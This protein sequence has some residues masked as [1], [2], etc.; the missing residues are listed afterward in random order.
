M[1]I[2]H[3][4][5][6]NQ[7]THIMQAINAT[8]FKKMREWYPSTD[9]KMSFF[10]CS[11]LLSQI[12]LQVAITKI[13]RDDLELDHAL[14]GE[15]LALLIKLSMQAVED[16]GGLRS[17]RLRRRCKQLKGLKLV[18]RI[19]TWEVPYWLHLATNQPISDCNKM[20]Q[21]VLDWLDSESKIAVD[22]I[23]DAK[24]FPKSSNNSMELDFSEEN[25][26][27]T[28]DD[29]AKKRKNKVKKKPENEPPEII[30]S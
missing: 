29:H 3:L 22:F 18:G 21:V 6:E 28:S 11:I 4:A 17:S 14:E 5:D 23:I 26:D 9:D 27:D 13:G 7:L 30:P 20:I 10:A 12:I 2:V 1:D 8:T 19:E 25:A 15:A 16:T 24:P